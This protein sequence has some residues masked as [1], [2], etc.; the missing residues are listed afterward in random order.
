MNS[1]PAFVGNVTDSVRRALLELDRRIR[2]LEQSQGV[3]G[4]GGPT[5]GVAYCVSTGRTF[6]L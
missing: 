3:G 1:F 4:G 5:L 6:S 2:K